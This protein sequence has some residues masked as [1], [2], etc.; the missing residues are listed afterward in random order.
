MTLELAILAFLIANLIA[1]PLGALAAFAHRRRA[2]IGDH[3]RS[4]PIF[5]AIPNFWL[6]TLL[7]LVFSL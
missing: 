2:D 5:G 7:V 4:P 3:A 6:A 1:V